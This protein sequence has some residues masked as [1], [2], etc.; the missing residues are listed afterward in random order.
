MAADEGLIVS[1]YVFTREKI[2]QILLCLS[3][4][5]TRYAIYSFFILI[6]FIFK[7]M[8][9]KYTILSTI[10]ITLWPYDFKQQH[11]LESSSACY[12][13]DHFV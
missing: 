7:F 9:S 11:I 10:L 12:G 2:F 8:I 1:L 3:K 5:S 6:R 4:L 13:E